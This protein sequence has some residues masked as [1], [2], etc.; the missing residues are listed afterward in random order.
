[1]KDY[2][3]A[4]KNLWRNRKRTL[5][6]AASIF[7]A[8]F[9]ALVMRSF[10]LGT[11]AKMYRDVIESYSGWLQLQN[12]D[13][14]D[15][16]TLDNGFVVDTSVIAS[17]ESDPNV[18]AVIPRLESFALAAAGNRT[19][20]VM[21]IGMDPAN[22]YKA[23]NLRNRMVRYKLTPGAIA[24]LK[25]GNLPGRYGKTLDAFINKPFTDDKD[26][27]STLGIRNADTSSVVPLIRKYA[28]FRNSYFSASDSGSA[29]IGNGLSDYLDISVGDTL[30]LMGQGYHGTSAA[31]LFI[32]R[33]VVTIPNPEIDNRFVYITL[34]DARYLYDA[35]GLATSAIIS[36]RNTGDQD[37]TRTQDRLKKIVGGDLTIRN[38]KE[39][40]ALLLNQ[41]EADNKSGAIMIAILYLVIAFGV[42]GTVLMMMAERRREFGMLVSI[43]MRKGRLA[44]VVGLEMLLVG[45]LGVV[46]GVA[47]SLPIVFYGHARPLRFTG[48]MARMYEDYGF[49]P[50]MPMLLPDTYYLWQV[51]V[52]LMILLI[53]IAFSVRK[54][55]RLNVINAL[56]A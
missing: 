22:E 40:N 7:F 48:E 53:A 33:G 34:K 28:A 29:I 12:R 30:V 23:L 35:P 2:Q 6:T 41:M 9:F 25:A 1:M 44:R 17:I 21:V 38:W 14:L 37:I 15:E 5:I 45:L 18:Q 3:L 10:Q 49:D 46:A 26:L 43:G 56:R 47:A 27:V 24:A 20:G 54:I 55:Y 42:F 19:Q 39:M 51:V 31:G 13:Y 50:V 52:V 11:Y 16:S 8:V 32:I 36:I 4:W